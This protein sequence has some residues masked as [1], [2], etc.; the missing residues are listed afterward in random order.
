MITFHT[1]YPS[2]P[3]KLTFAGTTL[4][5]TTDV[6]GN[7]YWMEIADGI[8]PFVIVIA[9]Q[10]FAGSITITG[11][12]GYV[13]AT[14]ATPPVVETKWWNWILGGI[15]LVGAIGTVYYLGKK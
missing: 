15:G 12:S 11:N 9:G 1:L 7:L 3:A 5:L 8:Y 6:N 13:D 4:S 10:T 2:T 14:T